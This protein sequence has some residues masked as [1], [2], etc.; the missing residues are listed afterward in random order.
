MRR[1]PDDATLHNHLL[2]GLVSG[3]VVST[4]AQ[5]IA[6]F[7]AQADRG[8][9]ISACA[10]FEIVAGNAREN[11]AQSV[12]QVGV[13]SRAD[14]RT[15]GEKGTV[16]TML[17]TVPCFAKSGQSPTVLG[18]AVS[19]GVFDRLQTLTE[20]ALDKHRAL[21]E[22]RSESG[23][24]RDTHGDLRLDHVY[25]F[26]ELGNSGKTG[27]EKGTVPFCCAEKSGQS[28]PVLSAD[29]VIID[30]IEFNER[31]RFADPV[32]D[33]AFLVMEFKFHGRGD[34]ARTFA[35]AYF[36]ATGDDEG[37]TLLPF[38]TSYR[39]AVRGKVEGL[40]MAEPEVPPAEREAARTTARAYWLLSLGELEQ[41][42]KRPALL[43]IGGLPGTGKSTL[44]AELAERA[45]FCVIRSDVVRKELAGSSG[46][47]NDP[48]GFER[49][50]YS[51]DWTQRT[52]D[53][54]LRQTETLLFEGQ[55]VIV[56]ANFRDDAHRRAF[57]E[58]AARWCVPACFFVC[59]AD[60][61]TVRNRLANRRGDASD[62]DWTIYLR[63]AETWQEPGDVTRAALRPIITDAVPT[64]PL[65]QAVS[66][67]REFQLYE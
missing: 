13:M 61:Q 35:D 10:R 57:L 64:K 39:A 54:C 6:G 22:R 42:S 46:V 30:C 59:Q 62:A 49:G 20:E 34:L 14:P 31:F 29:M 36:L 65:D 38:Y 19:R 53:E 40:K 9:H 33:I 32:A 56:D 2:R 15:V 58:M 52:Y 48:A 50:I 24:P 66:A 37:R 11:F 60:P 18:S 12:S 63:A 28:P 5:K 26:P 25:L 23:V 16:P 27:S 47:A 43:L 7:H 3:K 51:P 8:E 17:R 4:L 1:L 45:G 21:I 41:P 44:A 67:L 55:R